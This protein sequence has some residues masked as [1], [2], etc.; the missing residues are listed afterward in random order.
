MPGEFRPEE[1]LRIL[2]KHRVQYVVIGGIAAPLHGSPHVTSDIDITPERGVKNLQRLSAALTELNARIRVE[3]EPQGFKFNH[4]VDSLSWMEV[5]NLITDWGA[6]DLSFTP[7][8]TRG[9]SD[10]RRDAVEIEVMGV[11]TTVA[12]LADVVRSK[13][14]AGR[15][16][17]LLV[18][19]TLR[20]LLEEPTRRPSDPG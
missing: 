15:P 19:P 9:Y 13:E 20:R 7:A 2:E 17:D 3:G 5:L 11:H 10:L 16:K 1:I 12:S 18:L 8:G 14:A 4:D 6:L